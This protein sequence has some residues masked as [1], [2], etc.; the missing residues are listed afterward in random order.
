[1]SLVYS[2]SMIELPSPSFQTS[3]WG[4]LFT[5]VFGFS[6]F[7]LR[8]STVIAGGVLIYTFHQLAGFNY[9]KSKATVV[10]HC[11]SCV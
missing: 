9:R 10:L 8:L 2:K 6:F 4:S 7:V 11:T 5:K 1:M 3:L